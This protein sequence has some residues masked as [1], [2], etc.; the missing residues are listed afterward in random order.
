MSKG[1]VKMRKRPK[2]YTKGELNKLVDS[3]IHPLFNENSSFVL[4]DGL[5]HSMIERDP[6]QSVMKFMKYNLPELLKQLGK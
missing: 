1:H 5:I 6:P 2:R 4:V 3:L